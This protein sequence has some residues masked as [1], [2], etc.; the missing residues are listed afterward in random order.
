[1]IHALGTNEDVAALCREFHAAGISVL[2]DA[3]FNHVGRSFFAFADVRVSREQSAYRD[4]FSGLRF[5]RP[6]PAGDGLDYDT[7]DGHGSLVKLNVTHPPVR[8]YLLGAVDAWMTEFDIDGLRLDAAD[9]IDPA[10][11]GGSE[12]PRRPS[13][14]PGPFLRTRTFLAERRDG[15]RRLRRDL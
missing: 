14:P 12:K 8:D 6:G 11:L 2:L 13:I 9:V 5:D 15:P 7:W 1:L 10:L 3:V 4:W